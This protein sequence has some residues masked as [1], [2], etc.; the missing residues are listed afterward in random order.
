MV[1]VCVRVSGG[2]GGG[3]IITKSQ[4]QFYKIVA[5]QYIK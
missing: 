1:R 2:D 5:K 4:C 3:S